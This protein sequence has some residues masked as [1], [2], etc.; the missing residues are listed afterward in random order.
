M[1]RVGAT[2]TI[3]AVVGEVHKHLRAL[4]GELADFA[5]KNGFITDENA[6][7]FAARLERVARHTVLELTDLLG[8][9]A[10]ERKKGWKWQVF[11]EGH[12][13]NFVVARGPLSGRAD[14]DRRIEDRAL[15]IRMRGVASDRSGYD[16]QMGVAGNRAERLTKSWIVGKERR[17][18]FRPDDE[19]YAAGVICSSSLSDC[20]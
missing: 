6:E 5:G 9:S 18:R 7:S 2:V 17:G 8:E 11:A 20:C 3:P 10:G 12:K 13:M 16:P 1:L 15:R 14:Q 19:I 4:I